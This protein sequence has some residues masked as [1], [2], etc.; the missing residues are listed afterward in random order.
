M[1]WT[2]FKVAHDV[3]RI[4][5]TSQDEETFR[6]LQLGVEED[7]IVLR[8]T[9]QKVGNDSED[10]NSLKKVLVQTEP[11]FVVFRKTS[12]T[13]V[14]SWILLCWLPDACCVR[15]KLIYSS[16]MDAV[17]RS[18]GKEL[19]IRGGDYTASNESD[20]NFDL[21]NEFYLGGRS[22]QSNFD[23]RSS[24]EILMHEEKKR[25]SQL[26]TVVQSNAMCILPMEP[27]EALL[28]K[29]DEF[30]SGGCML[31]EMKLEAEEVI[32]CRSES[33]LNWGNLQ[34]VIG[35]LPNK[36]A[37]FILMNIETD[38]NQ[39]E[40]N[41]KHVICFVLFCPE[42]SSIKT[43]MTM[44]SFRAS[45]IELIHK[46]GIDIMKSIEVSSHDEVFENIQEEG[47]VR[48][49]QSGNALLYEAGNVAPLNMFSKPKGPRC[50]SRT[51]RK[52]FSDVMDS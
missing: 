49:T 21:Y 19:F 5:H 17:K 51:T 33:T 4:F 30:K 11:S 47:Q 12:R 29:L 36:E 45:V 27:S 31:V 50:K 7:H 43:K 9:L 18:L 48:R 34:S 16:S 35:V 13:E 2:N 46:R 3:I 20:L 41:R 39:D 24:K 26:S 23:L 25:S 6:G 40:E 32:V 28:T 42:G 52:K 37:R 22:A 44:S 10:F 8:Q 38:D 1:S 15:E 14:I